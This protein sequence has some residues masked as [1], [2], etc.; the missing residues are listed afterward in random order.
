MHGAWRIAQENL[1]GGTEPQARKQKVARAHLFHHGDEP[2]LLPLLLGAGYGPGVGGGAVGAVHVVIE[3]LHRIR[4]EQGL[5]GCGPVH[6]RGRAPHVAD[7]LEQLLRGGEEPGPAENRRVA[8]EGPEGA[9]GGA[10]RPT[11]LLRGR[12]RGRGGEREREVLRRDLRRERRGEAVAVRRDE[13]RLRQR[14]A[15]RGVGR[16]GGGRVGVEPRRRRRPRRPG[17]LLVLV[18]RGGSGGVRG[19][20]V[21]RREPQLLAAAVL[22]HVVELLRGHV[23]CM[24]VVQQEVAVGVAVAV[25]LGAAPRPSAVPARGGRHGARGRS[26]T[27]A[28]TSSSSSDRDEST[29]PAPWSARG[30]AAWASG[31]A[32]ASP[33]RAS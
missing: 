10:K 18:L 27:R 23:L 25:G 26:G 8:G 15:V 24:V 20:V 9:R 22:R 3:A 21:V 14:G 32:E 17:V 6:V 16:R 29:C 13:L 2:G 12:V 33:G 1:E 30:V 7:L 5:V 4:V 19:R 28:T 31:R 11:G